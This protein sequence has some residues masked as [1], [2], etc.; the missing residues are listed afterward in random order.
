MKEYS[1]SY[2]FDNKD[3]AISIYADSEKEAKRKF[4]ALKENGNTM[5]RSFVKSMLQSNII[6]SNLFIKRLKMYG[7]QTNIKNQILVPES[8]Y[9]G[10]YHPCSI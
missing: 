8:I 1:F 2:R 9:M 3:W 5:V 10:V 4:W 7:T 6:L